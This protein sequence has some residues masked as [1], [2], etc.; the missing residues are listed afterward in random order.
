MLVELSI[1]RPMK[2]IVVGMTDWKKVSS[3]GLARAIEAARAGDAGKGFAVV[4][5]EVGK[6][7]ND[8]KKVTEIIHDI[9]K[10]LDDSNKETTELAEWVRNTLKEQVAEVENTLGV[11]TGIKHSVDMSVNKVREQNQVFSNISDGKEIIIESVN[12]IAAVTQETAASTEEITATVS[13][14]NNIINEISEIMYQKCLLFIQ[15]GK[16]AY[17][18]I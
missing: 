4:A 9:I 17:N 1:V 18:L 10:K 7:A 11:F 6:L 2:E 8:S 12:S 16:S 13:E 15:R 3:Y 14:Q 5:T